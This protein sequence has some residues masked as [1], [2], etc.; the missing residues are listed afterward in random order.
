[1][2]SQL[3]QLSLLAVMIVFGFG[4]FS[5]ATTELNNIGDLNVDVAFNLAQPYFI[6]QHLQYG[7]EV[8]FT[9]GPWGV[10][11]TDF[12]GSVYHSSVLLFRIV[13]AASVFF[14]LR[15]SVQLSTNLSSLVIVWIGLLVLVLLW[16]TGQRE[17]YYLFPALFVAF[18]RLEANLSGANFIVDRS[19]SI[20]CLILSLLSGW[21]SLAKFNIFVVSTFA[22]LV[23]LLADVF[24]KRRPILPIIYATA[25]LLAWL[26][27]GQSLTNLPLW[28]LNCL[29]LSNGYIDAMSM[30]FFAPYNMSLVVLYYSLVVLIVIIAIIITIVSRWNQSA[31]LML[32]LTLFICGIS[33]KHGIGGN[34][35]EQSISV[36]VLILW[37]AGHILFSMHIADYDSTGSFWVKIG[38]FTIPVS[39]ILIAFIAINTNVPIIPI[40]HVVSGMESN[41]NNI[42]HEINGF[43][44][45]KWHETIIK[46]NSFW[47]PKTYTSAKSV[48][49]YPQQ[50]GVVIGRSG[51]DY[52][53][54]PAFLSLNAHTAELAQMN[55]RHLLD[56]NAPDLLLFQVLPAHLRGNN[57]YPALADGPSWPLIMSRYDL[58]DITAD[59]LV[60]SKRQSPSQYER[61]LLLE[62]EIA[63]DEN[64]KLPI[65]DSGLIWAEIE[66]KRSFWGKL[67]H[68]LYKSPHITIGT[69][70]EDNINHRFQLVPALAQAGF[71]LSPLVEDTLSFALLQQRQIPLKSLI[72]DFQLSSPDAPT[73]FWGKNFNLR[74]YEVSLPAAKIPDL[75]LTA[76]RLLDLQRLAGNTLKCL[77]PPGLENLQGTS[78]SVL[79]MHA[80]CETEIPV[81]L[82]RRG[83]VLKFGLQKDSYSGISKTDGVAIEII[84]ITADGKPYKKWSH[85]LNPQVN[86]GDQ[87]LQQLTINWPP[88]IVEKIHFNISAGTNGDPSYDHTFIQDIVF[89]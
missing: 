47:K 88:E 18:R 17:S 30:G 76:K 74:L 89:K 62:Q 34:Q 41:A 40:S 65:T 22:Y 71:L 61:K 50:T 80:P 79:A 1:M 37:L 35:I 57:R 60:F 11:L 42:W 16:L 49:I 5:G 28:V 24:S 83:L 7:K 77:F 58:L 20:L 46:A 64:I 55:A 21:V 54:R 36:L 73:G 27:A 12:T 87:G 70:T 2:V 6:E 9:Y 25:L 56:G 4:A 81:P 67:L 48:D 39:F 33:V 85:I 44:S 84:A 72:K 19:I 82:D 26:D 59:F 78:E 31:L 45:D 75:P 32:L 23:V 15:R 53:P 10:L 51:L 3:T 63:L 86:E 14:A 69:R 8:V 29:S 43:S 52:R 66:I 13:L 68:V 38:W